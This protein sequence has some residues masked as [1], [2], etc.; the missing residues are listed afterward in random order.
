M[1]HEWC[2][3]RGAGL[4][5]ILSVCCAGRLCPAM[6][7]EITIQWMHC[8][9]IPRCTVHTMSPMALPWAII[10]SP[11]GAVETFRFAAPTGQHIEAHG[12]AMG[13]SVCTMQR[14]MTVVNPTCA[15]RLPN[16]CA[17][18]L[19]HGSMII[20][21]TAEALVLFHTVVIYVDTDPPDGSCDASSTL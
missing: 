3:P 2:C 16:R 1:R 9:V 7:L 5:W 13:D 17:P 10:L 20:S 21:A 4:W 8:Q 11:F 6:E 15:Y 18:Q 19:P 14:G 12:N